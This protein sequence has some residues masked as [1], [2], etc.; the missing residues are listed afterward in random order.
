MTQIH[1]AQNKYTW[2]KYKYNETNT[3]WAVPSLAPFLISWSTSVGAGHQRSLFVIRNGT[4]LSTWPATMQWWWKSFRSKIFFFTLWQFFVIVS[5]HY[6]IFPWDPT[7]SSKDYRWPQI[8]TIRVFEW[9]LYSPNK[10]TSITIQ[11]WQQSDQDRSWRREEGWALWS[12]DPRA[13]Q[14]HKCSSL[15]GNMQIRN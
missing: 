4:Q 15:P 7:F 13:L 8:K 12:W 2:D 3:K 6:L 5:C 14:V 9:D 10:Y 11:F 1:S